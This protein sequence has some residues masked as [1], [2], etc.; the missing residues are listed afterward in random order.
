MLMDKTSLIMSK[1][2]LFQT[3][4]AGLAMDYPVKSVW[5]FYSM[6]NNLIQK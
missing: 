6:G 5:Q 1:G 4:K 3:N 2:S